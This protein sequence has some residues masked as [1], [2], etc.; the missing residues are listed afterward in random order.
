MDIKIIEKNKFSDLQSNFHKMLNK[1]DN[2]NINRE[3]YL[4]LLEINKNIDIL[5]S[6]IIDFNDTS[7]INNKKLNNKI[8]EI[9]NDN[10]VINDL[11]PIAF[12][13]RMLLKP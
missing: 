7:I 5:L 11:I 13:Y 6:N 8:K 9:E 2:K 4:K 12:I 3:Q 1:L 10:R